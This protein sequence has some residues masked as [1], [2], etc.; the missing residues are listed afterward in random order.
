MNTA[1]SHWYLYMIRCNAGSLYTGVT[2]D[3]ARRLEEH[4]SQGKKCAKYL[5]GKGP[6]ELVHSE[7]LLDK[8]SAYKLETK[9]KKLTKT[10]K[11]RYIRSLANAK[12]SPNPLK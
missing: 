8:N 2:I 9:I 6:L 10:E 7:K 12:I 1:A 3:V 4:Q 5:R 11:E